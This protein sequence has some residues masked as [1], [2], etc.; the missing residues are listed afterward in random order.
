MYNDLKGKFV[1]VTGSASKLGM[2]HD[3]CLRL[4]QEGCIVAVHGRPGKRTNPDD[5]AEGWEG[6]PSVVKE[7]EDMGGESHSRLCGTDRCYSGRRDV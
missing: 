3:A 2:G 4:A 1:L 6:V 5:I 7:I